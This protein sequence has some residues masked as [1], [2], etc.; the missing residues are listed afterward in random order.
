MKKIKGAGHEQKIKTLLT[1]LALVMLEEDAGKLSGNIS[2][3]EFK[4]NIQ[5]DLKE[6]AKK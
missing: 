2:F 4:F 1:E 3:N 5:V 6:R